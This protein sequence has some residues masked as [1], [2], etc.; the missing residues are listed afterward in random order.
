MEEEGRKIAGMEP[1]AA[2]ALLIITVA[3]IC[4]GIFGQ[5]DGEVD[6]LND[7]WPTSKVVGP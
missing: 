4:V 5:P 3:L 6:P 7:P 2:F 1:V